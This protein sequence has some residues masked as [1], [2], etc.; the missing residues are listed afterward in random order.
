MQVKDLVGQFGEDVAVRW[1]VDSGMRVLDRNWRCPDGE[2]DVVADDDGVVVFVEVKTR[3]SAEFGDPAEAV[4]PTKARRIHRL[5]ARW[6]SEHRE[7][8][9]DEMRFDIVSVLRARSGG[10]SITHFPAAF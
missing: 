9:S 5:A 7:V 3:S 6:L 8:R 10:I 1:L 4:T 2:L